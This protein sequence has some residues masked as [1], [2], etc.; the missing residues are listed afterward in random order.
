MVV[1]S[2]AT[3]GL[4]A[5]TVGAGAAPVAVCDAAFSV[6]YLAPTT[7]G[8]GFT[9]P[10]G[11]VQVGDIAAAC[12]GGD[13]DAVVADAAGVRLAGTTASSTVTGSQVTVVLD[14]VVEASSIDPA[15]GA[16]IVIVG[17]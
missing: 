8:G 14:Q 10:V 12:L 15:D 9:N 7:G 6:T 5:A 4:G 3:L 11:R 1:A 2:A 17:P 13:L 16:R